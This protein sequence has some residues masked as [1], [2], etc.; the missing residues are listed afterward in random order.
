MASAAVSSSFLIQ[1]FLKTM[2]LASLQ[3]IA[4]ILPSIFR[5]ATLHLRWWH[6]RSPCFVL[7]SAVKPTLVPSA[8]IPAGWS[9]ERKPAFKWTTTRLTCTTSI[10]RSGLSIRRLRNLNS[11]QMYS[12]TQDVPLVTTLHVHGV[13]GARETL[14]FYQQSD[15]REDYWRNVFHPHDVDG[16]TQHR[17]LSIFKIQKGG[18]DDESIA[19]CCQYL[20]S[21]KKVKRVKLS[22]RLMALSD[23]LRRVSRRLLF[24]CDESGIA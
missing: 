24:I 11:L 13:G 5:F 16:V 3:S 21:I 19:G 6:L 18:N 7:R 1:S 23:F 8:N 15:S 17:A 14:R 4:T 9:T 22:M 20:V 10:R 2:Q 12:G